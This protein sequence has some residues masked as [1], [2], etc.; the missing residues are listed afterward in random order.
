V[1]HRHYAAVGRST[2]SYAAHRHHHR[3]YASR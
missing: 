3:R 1:K 2:R